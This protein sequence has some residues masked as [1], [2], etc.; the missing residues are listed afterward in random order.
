MQASAG[1]PKE[2]TQVLQAPAVHLRDA[3][4][5]ASQP[6]KRSSLSGAE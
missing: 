4:V 1:T 6:S 2:L 5:T 3:E